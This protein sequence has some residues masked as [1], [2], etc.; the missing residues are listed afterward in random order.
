[1]YL[2]VLLFQGYFTNSI[3]FYG[4][5]SNTS[6]TLIP[7]TSEYSLPH[8]YFL[9]TV[10][11]YLATF[12]VVSVSM[13]RSYRISFIEASGSVHNI[14][15]HKIFCS[16]D[17]GIAN[18]KAAQLKHASIFT[19]L[20]EHLTRLNRTATPSGRWQKLRRTTLRIT[21]HSIVSLMIA[22]IGFGIWM[23]LQAFGDT[24]HFNTWS[25]LY[26]SIATN[27]TMLVFQCLFRFI[28]R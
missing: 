2:T 5:Y 6:F 15:T 25:A 26:V 3:L 12:V 17:F 7:G 1:M 13:A 18:E 21:T 9:T 4:F 19:E 24:D 28:S 16:W 8:A 20:R 11:M 14:L 27:I 23:L 10:V 22:S